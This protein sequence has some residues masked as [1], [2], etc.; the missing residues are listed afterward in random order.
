[1]ADKK[2]L[3]ID[4]EPINIKMVQFGLKSEGIYEVLSAASGSEGIE[5]LKDTE[6]DLVLLDLMM[7]EM[8]GFETMKRIKEFSSVPVIFMTADTEEETIQKAKE[9]GALDYLKKPFIPD[10]LKATV[11]KQC[12]SKS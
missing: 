6:V 8:D 11:K 9:L 10:D 4:D 3:V 2:I 12:C 1:M 7:P 5:V